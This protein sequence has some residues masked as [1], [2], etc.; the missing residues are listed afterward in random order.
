MKCRRAPGRSRA[1]QVPGDGLLLGNELVVCERCWL[2]AGGA[3]SVHAEFDEDGQLTL[4][5]NG[6]PE[7]EVLI[8]AADEYDQR[9]PIDRCLIEAGI[10]WE[11]LR[12]IAVPARCD[13]VR[14]V[15]ERAPLPYT[16][17]AISPDA[18]IDAVT[19]CIEQ[20]TGTE[21]KYNAKRKRWWRI[22]NVLRCCSDWQRRPLTWVSQEEIAAAVG[23]STRTVRRCVAW[24]QREGLLFEVLP[25][26]QMPRQ[27]VPDDET[28]AEQ[29]EREIRMAAA[30]AAENAAIARAKAELDAVRDGLLGDD[31]AEAAEVAL[32]PA[33][34]AALAAVEELEPVQLMQLV[35]VYELRVPLSDAERA[36]EA[37]ITRAHTKLAATPGEAVATHHKAELVPAANAPVYPELFAIGH[38]GQLTRLTGSDAADAL[39]CGNVAGLL[40][41]DQNGHPPKV[42]T[43]DQ[44]ESLGVQVVDKRPASPGSDK[45]PPQP[46]Q[47][48][49]DSAAGDQ[50]APSK[51]DRPKQPQSEA[52]QAAEWLLRSRLHPDLCIDVSVR[53][54]A[55]VIRGSRLLTAWD[56]TYGDAD[57]RDAAWNVGV[58][59]AWNELADLIHGVPEYPHLPRFVRDPRG[60]IKA[61]FSRADTHTPP[62]KAKII[63]RIEAASSTLQERRQT[64]VE[65]VRQSEI[66]TRRTAIAACVLCDEYGFFSADPTDPTAP[67]VRCNHDLATSG[68]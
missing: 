16:R 54:L 15:L 31:A 6:G 26:C 7:F 56:V 30:V 42:I 20:Q 50:A 24:L 45:E 62:S 29:A 55:G 59:V 64:E 40:R 39:T 58:P 61:R 49:S 35:P 11:T 8:A 2:T 67:V 53:W 46:G 68:W 60:W 37:A 32:F 13:L 18:W 66:A 1:P 48:G 21:F 51:G 25:G 14:W 34:R 22:A 57:V 9:H 41:S 4:T 3:D 28:A 19:A 5:V 65:F 17:L 33:D 36:E 38:D 63:R 27:T 43:I 23:C 10:R 47:N 12:H 52:V 44:L